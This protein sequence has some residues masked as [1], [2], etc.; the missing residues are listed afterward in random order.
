M[1]EEGIV[2]T[3]DTQINVGSDDLQK[4]EQ[5]ADSVEAPEVVQQPEIDWSK[6]GLPQFTGQPLD[7]VAQSIQWRNRKYGEQA[8]ELGEL[9]KAREELEKIRSQVSG[10]PSKPGVRKMTDTELALFA[11]K[12]NEN[13]YAAIDEFIKP[14]LRDSLKEELR[15][16]LQEELSPLIQE[17]TKELATQQELK[18][19][20]EK[21][22]DYQRYAPVMKQLMTDEYLGDSVPYE[23]VYQLAELSQSEP[24]VF[25]ETCALMRRGIPFKDAKEYASLRKSV[26]S[27]AD[28]TRGQV[29]SEIADVAGAMRKSGA[30]SSTTEP[31][32]KTMDD[33]FA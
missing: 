19:F 12:F 25:P 9:R 7:K 11:E 14:H 32:I 23:D 10:Q 8:N 30:S 22:P 31:E 6:Y 13:P 5:P 28:A 27:A 29:K 18:A 26:K 3:E 1:P 16:S 20:T 4:P 17:Q 15:K 2:S 33:A 24:S 21:H